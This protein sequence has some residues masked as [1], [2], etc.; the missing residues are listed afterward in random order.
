[1]SVAMLNMEQEQGLGLSRSANHQ[2]IE[3]P[4]E[5][6]RTQAFLHDRKLFVCRKLGPFLVHRNLGCELAQ[7]NRA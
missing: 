4:V 3:G 5:S 2:Q 1:M 7:A 6:N